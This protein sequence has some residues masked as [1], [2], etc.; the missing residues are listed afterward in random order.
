[1]RWSCDQSLAAKWDL[2]LGTQLKAHVANNVT[3][4][5]LDDLR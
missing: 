1:M 2:Q 5:L 4:P 3:E